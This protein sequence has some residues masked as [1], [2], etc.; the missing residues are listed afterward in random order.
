[1][2]K[3]GKTEIAPVAWILLIGDAIHNF[4][5]GLSIGAAFTENTLLG[6]SVSLAVLC[7]ELPHELG[8]CSALMVNGSLNSKSM[9]QMSLFFI[10]GNPCIKRRVLLVSDKTT[11]WF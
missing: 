3:D 2:D 10:F 1:M 7:E 4:V 9:Q 8:K 6:I 11:K 5:D